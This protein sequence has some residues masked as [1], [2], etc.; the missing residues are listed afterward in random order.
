MSKSIATNEIYKKKTNM[1]A[2]LDKEEKS[3]WEGEQSRNPKRC[4]GK[5]MNYKSIGD[6]QDDQATY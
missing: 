2:Y 3:R 5:E 4:A 6:L 1:F